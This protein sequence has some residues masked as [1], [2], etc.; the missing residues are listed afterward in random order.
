MRLVGFN[1]AFHFLPARCMPD[2][3]GMRLHGCYDDKLQ[4]VIKARTERRNVTELN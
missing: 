2:V 1:D 4:P 3:G